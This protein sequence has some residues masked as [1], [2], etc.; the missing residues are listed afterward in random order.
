M[1]R[2]EKAEPSDTCGGFGVI[3]RGVCFPCRRIVKAALGYAGRPRTRD[4][5]FQRLCPIGYQQYK[6][7]HGMP[8]DGIVKMLGH[9]NTTV[10]EKHYVKFRDAAMSNAKIPYS[11]RLSGHSPAR[12]FDRFIDKSP[13]FI[14]ELADNAKAGCNSCN[15]SSNATKRPSFLTALQS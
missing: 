3:L 2:A 4:F 15:F 8:M 9:A 5:S 6:H 10:T 13:F 11:I 14:R 12:K 1:E 7:E